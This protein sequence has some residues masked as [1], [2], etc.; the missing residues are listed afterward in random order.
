MNSEIIIKGENVE[1]VSAFYTEIKILK[2]DIKQLID[3]QSVKLNQ[4][5]Y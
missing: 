4:T 2:W 1:S 5:Q 3:G